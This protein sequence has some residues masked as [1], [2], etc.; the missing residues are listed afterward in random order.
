MIFCSKFLPGCGT[1]GEQEMISDL[2]TKN[3]LLAELTMRLKLTLLL[4]FYM[5]LSPLSQEITLLSRAVHPPLLIRPFI[6]FLR[7]LLLCRV[8][9]GDR[10]SRQSIWR[11]QM[12]H[13]VLMVQ[14]PLL[15]LQVWELFWTSRFHH[16]DAAFTFMQKLWW[17]RFS[18]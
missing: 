11:S 7:F 10:I 16:I 12:Q 6:R 4:H 3:G 5:L 15:H 13:F 18:W 17:I 8:L 14:V 1:F 2:T 9:P